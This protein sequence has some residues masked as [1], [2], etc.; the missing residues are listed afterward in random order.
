[1]G[2][3]FIPSVFLIPKGWTFKEFKEKGHQQIQQPSYQEIQNQLFTFGINVVDFLV[4]G[5]DNTGGHIFRIH[6]HGVAGGS[7]LEWCDILGH[8][9]I[10]AGWLHASIH[11]SLEGQFCG[12]NFTESV[13]NVYSAK[14]ISEL[15]PGVGKATDLA[16]ITAQGIRFFDKPI[17]DI[18]ELIRGDVKKIKP[19]LSKL[20][21]L[22]TEQKAK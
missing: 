22:L 3:T 1:M 7:W 9:E 2:S 17:F 6:Y 21:P 15:A 14:K 20:E 11:L 10:G 12:S 18:L 16:I 4:A 8:R 5:V 13:F 19:D